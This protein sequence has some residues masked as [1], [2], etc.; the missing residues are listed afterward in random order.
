MVSMRGCVTAP[1]VKARPG[2]ILKKICAVAEKGARHAYQSGGQD[3]AWRA[4]RCPRVRWENGEMVSTAKKAQSA[5]FTDRTFRSGALSRI[6]S[7]T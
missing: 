2:M 4:V 5:G 6:F 1:V 3:Q 7:L